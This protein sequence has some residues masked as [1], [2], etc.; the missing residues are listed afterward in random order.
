MSCLNK[1]E[2]GSRI[3][4]LRESNSETQ[5]HLAKL[6]DVK[7]QI[8]SYYENG[9][10][11]PNLE[12]LIILARHYET[13][14]DYLLGLTSAQSTDKDV[15]FVCE[16]LHLDESAVNTLHGWYSSSVIEML[17]FSIGS[18]AYLD[19]QNFAHQYVEYKHI[20]SEL[21]EF[22]E[23]LIKDESVYPYSIKS[24]EKVYDQYSQLNDGLMLTEF[25]LQ[26][27]A[28]DLLERYIKEKREKD[29]AIDK[30]FERIISEMVY[31]I[32]I[33]SEQPD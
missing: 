1:L 5:E 25:K 22:K 9:T 14:T 28:K 7:R 26:K 16:Y 33:A 23:R 13:S 29:N 11:V 17:N 3:K 4:S 20:L 30:E 10:R 15:Q 27:C 24:K 18:I 6:L 12:H 19:F 32:Q 31:D 2:I 21:V 8:I